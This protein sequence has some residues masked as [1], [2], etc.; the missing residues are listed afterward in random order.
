MLQG[1]IEAE[2]NKTNYISA[3]LYK[4]S[5]RNVPAA[6]SSLFNVTLI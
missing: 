4:Y 5:Y 1:V 6:E 2:T 3:T